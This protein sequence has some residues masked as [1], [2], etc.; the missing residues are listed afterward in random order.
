M[1]DKGIYDKG[2]IWNPSNCECN[3]SWDVGEHLDYKNCECRKKLVDQLVKE[4]SENI[5]EKELHPTELHLN[6]MI[7]NS[8]VNNYKKICSSCI[9]YKILWVIFF[10]I[11]IDISSVL[12]YFHYFHWYFKK[13][14][15]ETTIYW[16]QFH[17]TYK[18]KISNK[19]ILRIVHI[20]FFNDMINI[21]DF[22][23]SLI[24]TDKKIIQKHWYL[25]HWMH[26]NK[27]NWCL[28]KY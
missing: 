10:L 12:I 13:I 15:I 25:Q 8:T 26:Y 27:R 28:W 3:K 14:Y 20:T 22:D 24:K 19:L 11:S 4:C 5:N 18:W 7:Y 23:S 16:M 6:K 1:I 2:V 9:V 21:K 17:F